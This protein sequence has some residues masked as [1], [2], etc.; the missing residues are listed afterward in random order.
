M[1]YV[2]RVSIDT[3]PVVIEKF[4]DKEK[5]RLYIESLINANK[6][7]IDL[8]PTKYFIDEEFEN[9]VDK[10]LQVYPIYIWYSKNPPCGKSILARNLGEDVVVWDDVSHFDIHSMDKAL[11]ELT[12]LNRKQQEQTFEHT[13]CLVMITNNISVVGDIQTYIHNVN[14]FNNS[15][16]RQYIVNVCEFQRSAIASQ[17]YRLN[18]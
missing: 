1:Y 6:K 14:K 17:Y 7:S 16:Y 15:H 8:H 3:P 9:S 10:K 5:A 13:R 11:L 12:Y 18:D 4:D 2:K